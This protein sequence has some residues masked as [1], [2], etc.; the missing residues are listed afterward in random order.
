MGGVRCFDG[1]VWSGISDRD[2]L[3]GNYASTVVEDQQGF[4]WIGS[5]RGLNRYRRRKEAAPKPNITVLADQPYTGLAELPPITTRQRITFK[6][7][8]VDLGTRPETRLY[9]WRSL[10]ASPGM[11]AWPTPMPGLFPSVSSI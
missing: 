2:G 3:A 5:D 4:L 7:S 8:T 11:G 6:W 10:R 1:H 9:R